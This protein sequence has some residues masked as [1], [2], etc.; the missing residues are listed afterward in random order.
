MGKQSLGGA[1]NWYFSCVPCFSPDRLV[2]DV[3]VEGETRIIAAQS[4]SSSILFQ[5]VEG[6]SEQNHIF[7]EERNVPNHR[8]KSAG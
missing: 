3:L 1:R 4:Y 6:D 2:N 7:H 5:Q 8:G